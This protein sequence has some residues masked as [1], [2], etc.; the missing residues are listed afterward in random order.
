M[1][2]RLDAHAESW[3]L[4]APFS[5]SRGTKSSADVVVVTA[6]DG[7][8]EGRGEGVPYARYGESVPDALEAIG[9]FG[10]SCRD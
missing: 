3:E 6:R 2:I 9:A 10:A 5:I 8:F 4:A 1:A 7:E